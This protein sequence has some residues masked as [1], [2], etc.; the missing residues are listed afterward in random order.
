MKYKIGDK[1]R[2]RKDLYNSHDY[3]PMMD[4]WAGQVMTIMSVE[5]YGYR[6]CYLMEE[7][8]GKGPWRG[9]GK[10]YWQ[11]YDDMISGI[12]NPKSIVYDVLV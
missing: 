10:N 3:N 7:D 1:V 9:N 4:E 11:W 5:K 12:D 6:Y 2:I 8:Q